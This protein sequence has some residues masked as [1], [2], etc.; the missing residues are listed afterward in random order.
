MNMS[1]PETPRSNESLT[2][3]NFRDG[4]EPSFT[5]QCEINELTITGGILIEKLPRI[6]I[7]GKAYVKKTNI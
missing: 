4:R 6:M 3:L 2:I 1:T 5:A 7:N